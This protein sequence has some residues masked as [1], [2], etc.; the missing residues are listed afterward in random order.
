MHLLL[1]TLAAAATFSDDFVDGDMSGWTVLDGEWEVAGGKM[2]GSSTADGPDV[3]VDAGLGSTDTY[4]VTAVTSGTESLGIVFSYADQTNHC[5]IVFSDD[6]NMY[7]VSGLRSEARTPAEFI[8]N[9]AYTV[10]IEVSP[11]AITVYR[12]GVFQWNGEPNCGPYTASGWVGVSA[13]SGTMSLDAISV[14]WNGV[15][16]DGDGAEDVEDCAPDDATISPLE[17]EVWHDGID[18]DCRAD[19]DYDMDHDGY[20]AD[21]HVG[22]VTE[23]LEGSG[24]LPGGDCDDDDDDAH[25]GGIEFWYDGRDGDCDG[26][27]DFDQDGDGVEVEDDCSDGDAT[28]Y[29]GST[30]SENDGIDHDC[31][32]KI[33]KTSGG[34]EDSGGD[35]GEDDDTDT[36]AAGGGGTECGCS[37]G[38][39]GRSGEG[40]RSAWAAG[41]IFG[42]ALL[43][44]RR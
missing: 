15:D 37:S 33:E 23:N 17:R 44:R 22:L 5:A 38:E 16:T 41:M 4:T 27:N 26:A 8:A 3:V 31:D 12:N 10:K 14:T 11:T 39:L 34:G 32:G 35:G 13:M 43:L 25:P 36:G 7:L 30:T 21:E 1:S 42:L 18:T 24:E 6:G 9:H 2:S 19:D 40:N 28:T 20:V 29:P